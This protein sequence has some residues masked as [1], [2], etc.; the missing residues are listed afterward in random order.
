LTAVAGRNLNLKRDEGK[1]YCS[2][3]RAFPLASNKVKTVTKEKDKQSCQQRFIL[4]TSTA[5]SK[6]KMQH[7]SSF[8][9]KISSSF[10]IIPAL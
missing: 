6:N 10:L 8:Y 7:R 1:N 9:I 2:E 5:K 3:Q 4:L